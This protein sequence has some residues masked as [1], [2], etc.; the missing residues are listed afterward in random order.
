MTHRVKCGYCKLII[1]NIVMYYITKLQCMVVTQVSHNPRVTNP[2]SSRMLFGWVYCKNIYR[3]SA[4]SLHWAQPKKNASLALHPKPLAF[5]AHVHKATIDFLP[6]PKIKQ[7]QK[8][9]CNDV[10]FTHENII[11]NMRFQN[12]IP[13]LILMVLDWTKSVRQHLTLLLLIMSDSSIDPA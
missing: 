11:E 3:D 4:Q 2:S 10:P 6:E 8:K 7:N 1:K 5:S 9:Y 13:V 12:I